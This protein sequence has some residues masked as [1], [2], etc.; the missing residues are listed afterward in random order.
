MKKA[1]FSNGIVVASHNGKLVIERMPS[2]TAAP[3]SFDPLNVGSDPL[4]EEHEGLEPTEKSPFDGAE[5]GNLFPDEADAPLPTEADAPPSLDGGMGEVATIE[6]LDCPESDVDDITNALSKVLSDMNAPSTDVSITNF[7]GGYVEVKADEDTQRFIEENKGLIA[8]NINFILKPSLRDE[9]TMTMPTNIEPHAGGKHM[10]KKANTSHEENTTKV[11]QSAPIQLTMPKDVVE[12]GEDDLEIPR[13]EAVGFKQ[14]E[15]KDVKVYKYPYKLGDDGCDTDIVPRDS[16]GDGLGGEKV[17]FEAEKG[18]DVSSGNP[19]NYVQ[20]L[21]DVPEPTPAGSKENHAVAQ[22]DAL[23]KLADMDRKLKEAQRDLR[24]SELNRERE[25]YARKIVQA[26]I[27]RGL[28]AHN[29]DEEF[30]TR[31]ASMIETPAA[32]LQRELQRVRTYP[33]VSTVASQDAALT[34]TAAAN[35]KNG[36]TDFGGVALQSGIAAYT[37]SKEA[38][39]VP[40]LGHNTVQELSDLIQP[41]TKLGKMF[42]KG[43][44]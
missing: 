40:T 42:P 38:A 2:K 7:D 31:V 30:E 37:I 39:Y 11:A 3:I 6:G 44:Q 23:R 18:E 19:D 26:E 35:R 9:N 16:S 34:V 27:E 10:S 32:V 12:E 24:K 1:V 13:D 36:F 28:F 17:T 29:T 8:E 14:V 33:T 4:A 41:H 20:T 43:N 21:N 15:P 25:K 22:S 5:D